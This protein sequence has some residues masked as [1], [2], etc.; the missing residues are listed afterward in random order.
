MEEFVFFNFSHGSTRGIPKS[1]LPCEYVKSQTHGHGEL[2]RLYSAV[3]PGLNMSSDRCMSNSQS[4]HSR[5]QA[6]K[7][8]FDT[9]ALLFNRDKPVQDVI[10]QILREVDDSFC[11]PIFEFCAKF[12][13]AAKRSQNTIF[14]PKYTKIIE[15][16]REDNAMCGSAIVKRTNMNDVFK[17]STNTDEEYI[18]AGNDYHE[19]AGLYGALLIIPATPVMNISHYNF[20]DVITIG[21]LSPPSTRDNVNLLHEYARFQQNYSNLLSNDNIL[22]IDEKT[23][24]ITQISMLCIYHLF[25][26]IR[27]TGQL[28]YDITRLFFIYKSLFKKFHIEIV[29]VKEMKSIYKTFW[30]DLNKTICAN[31]VIRINIIS[32]ACR[33]YTG[34]KYMP[35]TESMYLDT[36][37]KAEKA[38]R[39]RI[40]RKTS[41]EDAQ[42]SD[43]SD[44]QASSDESDEQASDDDAQASDDDAPLKRTKGKGLI[45]PTSKRKN[46]YQNKSR[47]QRRRLNELRKNSR[48][49]LRK[50]LRKIKTRKRKQ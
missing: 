4:R 19:Y 22:V 42:A 38:H 11:K 46:R 23:H 18:T 32:F 9:R 49:E 45:L 26:I 25:T 50:K 33:S 17:Y 8:I 28:I 6:I 27:A 35:G 31:P 40:K 21:K 2:I 41:N 12:R 36:A 44:E 15:D 47:K 43:E 5:H 48:K 7:Q 1:E 13:E 3:N 10:D 29:N 37:H 24:I 16:C 39:R 14:N 34:I 20:K 30:D